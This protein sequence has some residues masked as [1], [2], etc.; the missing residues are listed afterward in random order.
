M[1]LSSL[2]GAPP[3]SLDDLGFIEKSAPEIIVWAAP[4]MFFF[5]ILEYYIS[6]KQNH[7]FY[8]SKETM[9]SVLVGLGNVLI[10]FLIKAALLLVVV[11]IYNL[12]P[13]RMHLNWW[14]FIPAYI[15][16]D[17]CSYWAHRVSHSQR[18]W[19]A[20]HIVHHSGE[21]YNLTVSFRLS[22]VQ[23]IKIIFFVPA[24][25]IGFHPIIIFVTNQIAVLFQFWVHTEYIRRL[26]PAIE[27]IFATPSNHRVHHGSQEQYIDRNFGATFIIWDRIFGTYEPEGEKVAYGLTTNIEHKANPLHIN[28]H[29]YKEIWKDVKE[30]DTFGEKLYAIFGSPIKID[31]AKKRKAA[32]ALEKEEPAAKPASTYQNTIK[33]LSLEG[34][35]RK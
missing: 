33:D 24:M 29:E 4:V 7:D 20:T 11:V 18:F 23:H 25:L 35:A 16:W 32:L 5:A 8:E 30:A 14:T 21:K 28:F 2:F 1:D 17:F 15:F 3:I 26:H 34:S 9:G 12:V 31:Q 19:W 13:W 22:W 27:Y 10:S 6:K